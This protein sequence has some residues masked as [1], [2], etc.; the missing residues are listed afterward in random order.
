MII[1]ALLESNPKEFQAKLKL[2]CALKG[3]KSVQIDFAD[4]NFVA[5]KT[6][7]PS[8]IKLPKSKLIFEAHL[9]VDNPTDFTAYKQ[10]GFD[11]IIVHYEAFATE[12][13]LDD[14][15]G[16]IRKLKFIPALAISPTT[17]VSV[18]KYFT[19]TI[20][21]FTLLAVL[22]GK[23]GQSMLP[24]CKDR[25]MELKDLAPNAVIEVDGGVNPSN[26]AGLIDAGASDCVVG[27]SLINGDIQENYQS[28]LQA[29]S[30]D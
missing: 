3:I 17:P 24:G 8:E 22:P 11:K 5:A 10:V 2:V 13:D 4:G 20:N 30:N 9:M 18:L 7:A 12:Q 1:P 26:I 23:Q 29:I 16:A 14:T 21:H 25:I 19:D 15:L 27:S 28:L 6:V